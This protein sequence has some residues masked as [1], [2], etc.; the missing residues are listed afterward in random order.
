MLSANVL[1][2]DWTP[3][4]GSMRAGSKHTAPK[5]VSEAKISKLT[6]FRAAPATK[7]L[8]PEVQWWFYFVRQKVL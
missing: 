8:K 1:P 7:R 4:K 5:S 2:A 3:S 6:L